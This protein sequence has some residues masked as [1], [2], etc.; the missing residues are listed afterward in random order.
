MPL[1][2]SDLPPS[3]WPLSQEGLADAEALASQLDFQAGTRVVSSDE[4]KAK[5]TAQVFSKEVVI[6]PRLRE[7]GRSW[8]EGDYQATA[9]RWLEGEQVD[10][11]ESQSHAVERM[12][13]TVSEAAHRFGSGVCLVSHGLAISVLV[14]DLTGVDRVEFWSRLRFP[15]YVAIDSRSSPV[16]LERGGA[17]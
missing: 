8:V 7:V 10:G 15:D 17:S 1:V 12:I 4:L 16:S 11:W 6:D 9:R 14:A 2:I 3:E 5:Q 13:E